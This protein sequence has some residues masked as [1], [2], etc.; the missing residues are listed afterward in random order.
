M[1]DDFADVARAGLDRRAFFRLTGALSAGAALTA[2]LAACGGTSNAPTGSGT[3][4]TTDG[5]MTGSGGASSRAASGGPTGEIDATLAF[6]F[7]GGFDPMN[8]SGAV[9]TCVN[10]HI[11]EALVDL[12]PISRDPY[13][14]L[15]KAMPASSDDGLTWTATLR[16]GAK[17]SDGTAVTTEDVAWSFTRVLDTANNAVLAPFITSWLDSAV[18]TDDK[19]VTF[20]LKQ[21][22]SLFPSRI[23]VIKIVPKSKT[24]DVDASKAFDASPV[25]SGPYKLDSASV[26]AGAVISANSNYN[27]SRPPLVSKIVLRTNKDNSAR[28]NDLQG[29]QSQ[30]IEAVPYL[31]AGSLQKP[32]VADSK[33]AFNGMYIMFN[34][35][36]KPFDDKRVRQALFYAIDMDKVLATAL[37]GYGEAATSYLD[38]G[39]PNYQ[40]ASTV[41]KY[42]PERAKNLLS[43]AGVTDLSFEFATT[44]VAFI[45]DSAPV[46]IDSWKAIGVN[47]TLNTAPTSQVLSEIIPSDKFRVLAGSGDPTIY[48]PDTDLLLRWYYYGDAWLKTRAR[49]DD[50]NI[51]KLGRMIDDASA[52]SGDQQKASWK[53]IFDFIADE[54]P[55]YMVYHTKVIT[56]YDEDKLT[57]FHGAST[58]GVF[59]LNVGRKS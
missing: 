55:L 19:T 42:D 14:A 58:T 32:L 12:D 24:A 9:G 23:A 4:S 26:T 59:F 10:Q 29:G 30:A 33:Q 35:S 45:A 15:A 52:Q 39:N 7:N 49:W 48:G 2:T 3:D 13:P 37:N 43:E 11:F 27:G 50:A 17:F 20:K 57:N 16:D 56:G 47:A 22:F 40:K 36:A 41:Y 44:D 5:G 54:V 28:M 18:A 46:I 51:T 6:T 34:C 31:N 1:K 21:P 8:T 25:G 38:S 53:A